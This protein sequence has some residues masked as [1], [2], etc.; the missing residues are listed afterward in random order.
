M[1]AAVIK[2]STA[3]NPPTVTPPVT[4]NVTPAGICVTCHVPLVVLVINSDVIVVST[5]TT[6]LTVDK[7]AEV[8]TAPNTA[9]S[10]AP[11][12]PV[13][14]FQSAFTFQLFAPGEITFHW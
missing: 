1:A 13:L 7:L 12:L 4:V 3:P 5:L 2:P 10:L 14:G 9:V 6:L 11:G 8:P